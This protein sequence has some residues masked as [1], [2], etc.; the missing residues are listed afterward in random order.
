VLDIVGRWEELKKALSHKRAIASTDP[1]PVKNDVPTEVHPDHLTKVKYGRDDSDPVSKMFNPTLGMLK[2]G[3]KRFVVRHGAAA[4]RTDVE[5]QM[6][7]LLGADHMTPDQSYDHGLNHPEHHGEDTFHPHKHG[8][9]SLQDVSDGKTIHDA[10]ED[11]KLTKT[12]REQWKNG[13]LHKLWALHYISNNGDMHP[14]NFNV[15]KDGVKSFDSDHAFYELPQAHLVHD[16]GDGEPDLK[17]NSHAF[18]QLP[19]YLHAFVDRE[20]DD[21]I[22]PRH[23]KDQV[24]VKAL[25]EHAAN[26]NTDLFEQFGPHAAER[27][28]KAKQAL[29][30]ADPTGEMMKLWDDH[31]DKTGDLTWDKTQKAEKKASRKT[32]KQAA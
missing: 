24:T 15:T 3:G 5:H 18:S 23:S 32:K 1:I 20:N 16:H 8:G 10:L 25:N 14:G 19:S 27:A 17:Y 21:G 13:D 7:K 31:S 28:A 2:D 12:L 30:S 29:M 9:T 11:E 6:A 26:I 4:Q 22:E